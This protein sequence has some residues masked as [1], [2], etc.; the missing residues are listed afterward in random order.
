MLAGSCSCKCGM[1]G[2]DQPAQPLNEVEEPY[3][4]SGSCHGRPVE[5]AQDLGFFDLECRLSFKVSVMTRAIREL[6][7]LSST[8]SH[9]DCESPDE[10]ELSNLRAGP[11]VSRRSSNEANNPAAFSFAR[12]TLTDNRRSMHT[13]RMK[14]LLQAKMN[15]HLVGGGRLSDCADEFM[16]MVEETAGFNSIY[17]DL[18]QME[19]T[20]SALDA[21]GGGDD[22]EA[23]ELSDVDEGMAGEDEAEEEANRN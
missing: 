4:I 17:E 10:F 6:K 21:I 18:A 19:E 15:G 20:D 22:H 3:G 16:R 9:K 13:P 14:Q 12:C 8:S 5:Y 7:E 23:A 2:P 1:P 11:S